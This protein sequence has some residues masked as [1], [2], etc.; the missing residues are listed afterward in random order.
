MRTENEIKALSLLEKQKLVIE[1]RQVKT[2]D[3]AYPNAKAII[4]LITEDKKWKEP[5]P[6]AVRNIA[7]HAVTVDEKSIAAGE[8]SK[9]Y[10]WQQAVLARF[11]EVIEEG[12][13][14]A[15]LLLATLLLLFGVKASAQ[16][17]IVAAGDKSGYYVVQVNDL[18]GGTANIIA[19]MVTNYDAPTIIT[20][21]QIAPVTL[22]SNGVTYFSTVTNNT[23]VTNYPGVVAIT[24]WTDFTLT[25]SAAMQAGTTNVNLSSGW[26]YS[27]NLLNWQTNKW[28]TPLT[29]AGTGQ[30]T[31]N[32]DVTGA[33]GGYI[34]FRPPANL[35]TAPITNISARVQFKFPRN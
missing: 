7:D 19:G 1:L 35:A 6:V 26:D 10:P 17:Q 25:V 23:Y 20:N 11:L 29:L 12:K 2:G 33:I 15:A 31:T 28:L 14:A 21:A 4:T 27:D 32:L 34:R 9:V 18:G 13:K 22:V 3:K 8:E 16:S 24:K 30:N 5:E